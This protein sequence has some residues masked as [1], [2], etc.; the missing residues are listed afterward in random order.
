MK[1]KFSFV[2]LLPQLAEQTFKEALGDGIWLSF[3]T[4]SIDRSAYYSFQYKDFSLF[5]QLEEDGSCIELPSS[6][7]TTLFNYARLLEQV[8]DTEKASNMYR[9]ILFKVCTFIPFAIRNEKRG[10]KLEATHLEKAKELYTKVSVRSTV[11]ELK[12]AVC[13]F[14][15]LSAASI[16]HS[17]GFDEKKLETHVEY[18]KHLLDAA[19]VHCE[20]AE[21]EEQ[22]NRQ[23]LEVARQVSLAEEARRKA[24]E[25]RKFQASYYILTLM[26]SVFNS[27]VTYD[28]RY[29]ALR[30][31]LEISMMNQLEKRKQEDELKQVM[32]QEEHFER[33]K[34]QWKHSSNTAGKRRERSQVE[35]EEGGDRRRRRG[36]KRRRKE[37]KMK[38][39]YEEEADMEDEHEDLEEDTNAMNEYEDDGAEK[40]QNDLIAAGLEDSDAEDDLGAHSTAINRK[41]RAWSESD[42]DDEPFGDRVNPAETDEET[43]GIKAKGVA[44]DDDEGDN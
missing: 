39:R 25:Q 6:K 44:G 23:R 16:Y 21:R 17:H 33:I 9:L 1:Q 7:V 34:E 40:A 22:Q 13:I 35:D 20:A 32:Q 28:F 24:E 5:H 29:Q 30:P 2:F 15:Q 8:N 14:S 12:N 3:L 18:C 41:R 10:P 36:G 37:K 27:S 31:Y 4:G 38:T 42:E 26:C 19:K 11:T 43:N